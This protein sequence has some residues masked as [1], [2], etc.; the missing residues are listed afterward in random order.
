MSRTTKDYKGIGYD[1]TTHS[2][3]GSTITFDQTQ[4]GGSAQVGKLVKLK[5]G[6]A[7][8][9]E[10]VGAGDRIYGQLVDVKHN[11]ICTV[12]TEGVA[13]VPMA[14]SHG[15]AVGQRIVGAATGLATAAG[16]DTDA[17]H[18]ILLLVGATKAQVHFG[19]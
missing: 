16:A 4:V 18:T 9:V 7:S 17:D 8:V 11:G 6:T 3:D 5:S 15:A 2:I 19:R 1:G 12:Q 13:E 10:L 14:A